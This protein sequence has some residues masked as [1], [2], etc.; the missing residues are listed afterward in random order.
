MVL[1]R[2]AL[3]LLLVVG[4][5]VLACWPDYVDQAVQ[6]ADVVVVAKVVHLGSHHGHGLNKFYNLVTVQVKT[7]L[8]GEEDCRRHLRHLPVNERPEWEEEATVVERSDPSPGSEALGVDGVSAQGTCS[9]RVRKGDIMI[10]FLRIKSKAEVREGHSAEAAF[11]VTSQPIKLNLSLLRHT[12]AVMQA[13][14]H[15]LVRVDELDHSPVLYLVG[16]TRMLSPR[17]S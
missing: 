17:L 8:K 2:G 6:D 15:A 5:P 4:W 1:S 3:T 14:Y 7:F 11:H 12:Q 16:V 10:F 13:V 9:G